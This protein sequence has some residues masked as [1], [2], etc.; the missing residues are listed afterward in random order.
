LFVALPRR[1]SNSVSCTCSRLS[2]AMRSWISSFHIQNRLSRN[3]VAIP[4]PP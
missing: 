4:Y 2:C 1:T 3:N